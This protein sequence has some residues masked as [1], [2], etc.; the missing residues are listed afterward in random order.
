MAGLLR[1]EA[2]GNKTRLGALMGVDRKTIT[3][4]L[5]REFA[6]SE[7]NVRQVATAFRLD[8]AELLVRVGYY[9][10]TQ[11]RQLHQPQV[12]LTSDDEMAIR[13][14]E[15]SEAP[16]SLKRKLIEHVHQMR[17][18]D[19]ARRKVE[20]ERMLDIAGVPHPLQ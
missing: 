19:E 13:I 15:E 12:A 3:R 10:D 1:D 16:P 7:A 8:V 14:I 9:D 5:A 17:V 11:V 6:V 4:W 18:R 2:G 20:V